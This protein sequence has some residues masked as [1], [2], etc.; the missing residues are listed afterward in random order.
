MTFEQFG[1]WFLTMI[2]P[3]FV[4]LLVM[5]YLVFD[6]L[7]IAQSSGN[8]STAN[9]FKDDTGKESGLRVALLGAWALSSWYLM[10]DLTLQRG[11]STTLFALYL[12]TWSGAP[13]FVRV[14]EKWDG[15]LPTKGTPTP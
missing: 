1:V 6:A 11:G 4:A 2:N 14:L 13:V 8:F 10:A 15:K 7:K 3:P 9:M 12:A 5:M